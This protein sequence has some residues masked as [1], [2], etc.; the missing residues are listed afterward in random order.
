[1]SDDWRGERAPDDALQ[2]CFY[3]LVIKRA[4][5]YNL[6]QLAE[7]VMEHSVQMVRLIEANRRESR[8]DHAQDAKGI[9]DRANQHGL[10]LPRKQLMCGDKAIKGVR[11]L[12]GR[13]DHS[14]M[15]G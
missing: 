5:P 15:A 7:N 11:Q 9:T 4:H 10:N 13:N 2:C 14:L 12:A 8:I 3:N 6:S 1:V